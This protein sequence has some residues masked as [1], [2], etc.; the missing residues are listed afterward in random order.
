MECGICFEKF[1]ADVF[2]FLPCAHFICS[3]C[4][5]S[6]VKHECPYCKKPMKFE[7]KT[8]RYKNI[9]FHYDC[10]K[11]QLIHEIVAEPTKIPKKQ[12]KISE[13]ANDVVDQFIQKDTEAKRKAIVK[14]D[15]VQIILACSM[16]LFLAI[17]SVFFLGTLSVVAMIFGGGLILYNLFTA[18]GPA[19]L[20]LKYS[21]RGPSVFITFLFVTPFA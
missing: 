5:E 19:Y 17:A 1:P 13:S 7:E 2:K 12:K 8:Q 16:L 4:Y 3:F 10:V 18:R 11:P 14:L 6:L 21:K 9:W 15:P 20:K